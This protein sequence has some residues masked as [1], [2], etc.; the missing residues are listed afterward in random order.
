[1]IEN[2]KTDLIELIKENSDLHNKKNSSQINIQ[3]IDN[4]KN[5]ICKDSDIKLARLRI[6]NEEMLKLQREV[7]I[8]EQK[9]ENE[10]ILL[11]QF[12][13]LIKNTEETNENLKH[14][15]NVYYDKL[16]TSEAKYHTLSAMEHDMDGFNRAV[17]SIISQYK[18]D[19]KVFGTISD[20]IVVPKGFE[21]AIETA[22]SAAVQN[23]VT[24]NENTASEMI[25][26]LKKN[27]LG[28]ATFL[29]LTTIKGRKASF[30]RDISLI[31]GY[32]GLASDIVT[33]D[34]KFANAVTNLLGRILLC[35]NLNSAKSIANK[36]DYGYKIVTL[37]GDVVN[38]GGSFTGGSTNLKHIGIFSR[39]TEINELKTI[40]NKENENLKNIEKRIKDNLEN[41]ITKRNE[42]DNKK[43]ALQNMIIAYNNEMSNINSMEKEKKIIEENIEEIKIE[44]IQLQNEYEKNND[45]IEKNRISIDILADKQSKLEAAVNEMQLLYKEYSTNKEE[46]WNNIT[47]EKIILAE[48]NKTLESIDESIKQLEKEN[49]LHKQKISLN[50]NIIE[51]NKVRTAIEK[52][53]ITETIQEIKGISEEIILIRQKIEAIEAKKHDLSVSISSHENI[54]SKKDEE[55]N[56]L[57]LS[58]HKL[59]IAKS[60]IEAETDAIINKLWED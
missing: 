2:N 20:L 46:F 48:K 8:L 27:N 45:F 34:G 3:N 39:K 36:T 54:I 17:K 11:K 35:D 32:K 41:I 12:E 22:L 4:R 59:D 33:F 43:T 10:K 40:I 56:D 24:D 25:D 29:P 60:K 31:N 52:K 38:S 16:K 28:R 30:G 47:R 42:F 58:I 49:I 44:L 53:L 50:K 55:L 15:R 37:D 7:N 57:I 13:V 21:V 23:I 14:E 51:E 19:K 5:Q 26:F 1:L 9:S 18:D 6:V